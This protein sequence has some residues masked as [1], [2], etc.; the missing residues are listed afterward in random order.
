MRHT[1]IKV[2]PLVLMAF[3]S[4]R[5]IAANDEERRRSL[6]I[7]E[8]DKVR[9]EEE[10]RASLEAERQAGSNKRKVARKTLSS[11][12]NATYKVEPLP[13]EESVSPTGA[14]TYQIPI[15]TAPGI[16]FAPSIAICYN[17]QS[18]EGW[19]GYGWD[20]QGLSTI[21]LISRTQ[22]YHGEIKAANVY[23]TDGVFALK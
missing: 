20:I 1:L 17:S 21:S 5:S 16:K 8:E 3:L 23:D 13:M 15:A 22:Y 11:T 6:I 10:F 19:A 14:R 2:L 12:A 18:G 7:T 4:L 9:F